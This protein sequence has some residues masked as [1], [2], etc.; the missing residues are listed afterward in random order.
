MKTLN[1]CTNARSNEK[2]QQ[3]LSPEAVMTLRTR[4]Y[5]SAKAGHCQGGGG[6]N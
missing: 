5:S 1:N 4:K 2:P 6:W 3:L